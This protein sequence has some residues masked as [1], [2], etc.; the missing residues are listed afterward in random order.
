M[1]NYHQ[2]PESDLNLDDGDIAT[3]GTIASGAQTITVTAIAATVVA[4]LTLQNTT[5]ATVGAQVQRSPALWQYGR[6]WDVNDAVSRT[7]GMG[8]QMRPVAGNTVT[9]A[10]HLLTDLAGSV[11]A[12][13]LTINSDGSMSFGASPAT[14]G[15]LRFSH[16]ASALYGLNQAGNA[17][18]EMM[19]W[20]SDGNNIVTVGDNIATPGAVW[21]RGADRVRIIQGVSPTRTW[22]F[23]AAGLVYQNVTS[24]AGAASAFRGQGSTQASQAGGD[25]YIDPGRPG[26][27]G[28][29][30]IGRL[31]GNRDD[32]TF[33]DA[34]VWDTSGSAAR[35]KLYG[36]TPIAQQTDVGAAPTDTVANLAAWAETVRTRIR[37]IGITA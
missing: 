18:R 21:I 7:F 16:G 19:I 11:S 36:G 28:T 32:S 8:W 2:D 37:N 4:G 31:R 10:L 27:G 5:A 35:C 1:S 34:F 3:T 12:A 15:V 6:G 25:L 29:A 24:G 23:T 9:G 13:N 22:D 26:A 33:D 20:G 14:S 30:G 17:V